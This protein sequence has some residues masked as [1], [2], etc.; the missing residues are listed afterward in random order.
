MSTF[1]Q[2]LSPLRTSFYYGRSQVGLIIC[3]LEQN[4]INICKQELLTVRT[5]CNKTINYI[6]LNVS[7]LL[8]FGSNLINAWLRFGKSHSHVL[9]TIKPAPFL[10]ANLQKFLESLLTEICCEKWCKHL[11]GSFSSVRISFHLVAPEA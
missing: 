8:L 3:K 6:L 4:E 10:G 1:D 7:L 11:K 9:F 5:N 2:L